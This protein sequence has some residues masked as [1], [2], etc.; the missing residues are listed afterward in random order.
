MTFSLK[1]S[2]G[3]FRSLHVTRIIEFASFLEGHRMGL[4][5]PIRGYLDFAVSKIGAKNARHSGKRLTRCS[6]KLLSSGRIYR[7][8]EN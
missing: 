1:V 6:R 8:T 5:R 4:I 3:L 2:P 7:Q